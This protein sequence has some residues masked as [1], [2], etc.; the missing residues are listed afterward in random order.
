MTA[1][2]TP[3]WVTARRGLGHVRARLERETS[4]IAYL[5]VSVTAQRDG[6]RPRLHE[7]LVA[8]RGPHLAVNAG[9][10]GVGS[11]ACAFLMDDFVLP[12][13]PA[14]CFVECTTGDLG[15]ATS[16]GDL[17]AA[18]EGIILKLAD[19]GC[20]ACLFHLFRRDQSFAIPGDVLL[21][22]ERVAEHHGVPSI[23]LYRHVAACAARG[24]IDLGALYRDLVHTTPEGSRFTA[25]CLAAAVDTLLDMPVDDG[26]A[27]EGPLCA[28]NYLVSSIV[29][30]KVDRAPSPEAATTGVFG[31][32]YRYAEVSPA[33]EISFQSSSGHLKGL[34]LVVGPA[35]GPLEVGCETRT[36]TCQTWDR[37][38]SYER[39]SVV[40]FEQSFPSGAL[41]RVRPRVDDAPAG[42]ST[43]LKLIGWLV[44]GHPGET[45][46]RLACDVGDAR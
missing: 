12:A 17:A 13:R 30:A 40:L 21:A 20:Q 6:F 38:C 25:D 31:G 45:V 15:G 22:Y 29:P 37:W 28:T 46:T 27:P 16:P 14:L 32:R 36:D 18:V 9:I 39:L 7:R 4:R 42:A 19:A 3:D 43:R 44:H 41:V 5:G 10:G 1:V 33:Q 11:L 23:H 34:F 26:P 24:E 8:R 35:S 2:S